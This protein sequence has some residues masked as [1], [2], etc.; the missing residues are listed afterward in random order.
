MKRIQTN[1]YANPSKIIGIQF[2]MLSPEEIRKNSV[3]EIVSRES[4]GGLFDVKMG[5][6]E[7][8]LFCPTDG[9][10]YMD[11]PGYF[12]HMELA[13]PVLFIQHFKD[14]MKICKVVCYKCSKLLVNKNN[15]KHVAHMAPEERWQAISHNKVTRCGQDTEDG[16]GCKQPDKIKQDGF[17]TLLAVWEKIKVEGGDTTTVTQKLSPERI[18]KMFKRISDE[19]VQFMGF[20]PLWSRP[21]W[22]VCYALPVP[23]PAVRPSVKHDAQQRSEDDLTH[24]YMNILKHNNILKEAIVNNAKPQ[25]I[26]K[27]YQLLQYFVTMVAN[28]KASGTSPMGQNSGRTF[29]CISSRLN[30]KNGR[31]RGNL[32]GKRVDFS[33][34]SVI[35]GDPN[36]SITQLGVP[37]KI[38]KNI[39]R[40]CVVNERSRKF[41]TKL[42]QNGPDEYPGANRLERLN[43]DQVSLRYVDRNSIVLE[44]GDKVHRHMMDGDYVLFNR[45]PSLHKMSMMCH[46]VKVMKKGDTFRFNVAVTNP[47]NADFDGDEMNMH[48]PQSTSAETELM[49]LPAVTE[50]LISPSKN[51]PIIGIFQDSLLGC[52]RFTRE[53]VKVTPQ[54]CMNLLMMC[55]RVDATCFDK[56]KK[57]Y[58]SFEILSHIFPPLTVK[59]NTKNHSEDSKNQTIRIQNG[60]YIGG[61]LEKTVLGSATKG[62]LHR[63]INNFNNPTCVQFIDDLQNIITEYMKTSSF[64]VGISDLIANKKTK[65]E[66]SQVVNKQKSDVNDLIQELHLGIYENTSAYSNAMDFETRVNNILNK[67]TE[68]AGKIGRNSLS[69]QNRFLMIVNSGSKGSPINISQ[70]LSCLGQQSVEGKRVPYGFEHRTLPHFSKYDDSPGARGFIENSFI[71]GL[72]P[73]EMFFH[74]MAGRIGLIDTAVKTSETGYI[75]RRIIKSLEDIY[76]TYDQTV[77]NHMGKIVQFSYGD[78]CF[79]SIKVE[80]QPIKLVEM[81]IEDIYMHFDVIGLQE[82]DTSKLEIMKVFTKST[83]ARITKQRV[84]TREHIRNLIERMIKNRDKLVKHVFQYKNENVVRLPVAFSQLVISVQGQMELDETFTVDIT[85]LELLDI[86]EANYKRMMSYC[87]H[88]PEN[89]LFKIMYDFHLSPKDLLINRRFHKKAVHVLM[90]TIFLKFK[91]AIVHPG[92]MVGVIAAQSVGEPTTQLTLNTFHNVGVASKSNVTRGVPRIEEILRLTKN[93]KNPSLSVTLKPQDAE[94]QDRAMKYAN[95]IEHTCLQNVVKCVQIYF[96]PYDEQSVIEEDRP[97]L[98]QY[99]A[100]E[101]LVEDFTNQQYT[102][103]GKS[104]W[105]IRMEMDADTMLDKNIRM[106]DIYF[107]VNQSH[108]GKVS[109]VYSDYNDSKLIFR[110]RMQI[111]DTQKKGQANAETPMLL[112]SADEIYHLKNFQE[113]LL[114]RTILRG[115]EGISKVIPRKVPNQVVK[116][117]GKYVRR[118]TWVLDTTGTNLLDVLGLTFIDAPRTY[119]NDIY[120]VYKTLGIEAARQCILTEFIDVMEHSDVY[121]N[122]HHLSV[123]C[124]RMTYNGK[125]MV[126]VYRSGFLKDNIGP[127]AKATFEMHTEMFL[128]AARHGQMDNMRGVSANVMCG[129]FGYFGTGAFNLILDLKAIEQQNENPETVSFHNYQ[130]EA[131]DALRGAKQSK[132]D[133]SCQRDTVQMKN[134]LNEEEKHDEIC[135]DDYDMGF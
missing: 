63:I 26:D 10:T 116:Y 103:G 50:Q 98:E 74:A 134:Y 69:K 19:D 89:P 128:N 100:Y 31:V 109:C 115:V 118:D 111:K 81:S 127:I 30:T 33:A 79:D 126:A 119:S 95:M 37:M 21:E 70:M 122:Y 106:D 93:P 49:C 58:S 8:G 40:P 67:A 133:I 48:M 16:C 90:D 123:L 53:N 17:A 5:V 45:Q 78:D 25:F 42:V 32:M 132:K 73:Y 107:A 47:Y 97:M 52:F 35:T 54:E 46:E 18:Y 117:D 87:K 4:M 24:I 125:D 2:S 64:S 28:N 83:A 44:V 60:R 14:I 41:L 13:M 129:Q 71:G 131:E 120:E 85:P 34:R 68:Q 77:R 108:A 96:D 92:E 105:I 38:A 3:V 84:A 43:G 104:K 7:K 57:E 86:L 135:D 121:V 76:V 66:I 114:K 6:L 55:K 39:T 82:A 23:P 94:N 113:L 124:D 130:D 11:T 36:L 99:F 62:I 22:M 29:Q 110:F 101:K 91:Q 51:A 1:D 9:L 102:E 75:Q 112:D 72:T 12:G 20:H 65:H 88:I 56:K 59:L 15:F 80:N 61:Q 27:H